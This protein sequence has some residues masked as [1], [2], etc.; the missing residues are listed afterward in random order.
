MPAQH[1]FLP[2][3]RDTQ[4]NE[5]IVDNDMSSTGSEFVVNGDND[6]SEV[7]KGFLLTD[8]LFPGYNPFLKGTSLRIL[9]DSAAYIPEIPE[10]GDYAVYISYPLLQDNSKEVRYQSAIQE[11]KQNSLSIRRLEEKH[12]SILGL[13][14]SIPARA[15]NRFCNC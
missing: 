13:L 1:V 11:V 3:E 6:R 12:G 9:D 14:I 8:T 15:I 4:T 7:E 10:K 5:I 2:R